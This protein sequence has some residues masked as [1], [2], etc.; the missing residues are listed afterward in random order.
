VDGAVAKLR[1]L[2][3]LD[4]GEARLRLLVELSRGLAEHREVPQERVTA[5]AV[6]A[7]RDELDTSDERPRPLAA[8][9]ISAMSTTSRCIE[10]TGLGEHPVAQALVQRVARH[11]IDPSARISDSSSASFSMSH[12]SRAPGSSS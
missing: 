3:P 4:V 10:Q 11:Q 9:T 12:P 6:G 1:W 5:Q 2:R 7:E 8:S